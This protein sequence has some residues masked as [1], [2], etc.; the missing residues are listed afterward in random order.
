M[1]FALALL[2]S[3]HADKAVVFGDGTIRKLTMP[4]NV[5]ALCKR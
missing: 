2:E 5:W 4:C 1:A 3:S